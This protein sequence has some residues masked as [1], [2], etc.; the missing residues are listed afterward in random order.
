VGFTAEDAAQVEQS[1]LDSLVEE[2]CR[3]GDELA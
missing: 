3:P 1:L 2:A